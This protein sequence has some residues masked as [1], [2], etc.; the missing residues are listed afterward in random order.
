MTLFSPCTGPQ[1]PGSV[2]QHQSSDTESNGNGEWVTGWLGNSVIGWFWW[3]A[4]LDFDMASW[5]PQEPLGCSFCTTLLYRLLPER[6][7]K[8]FEIDRRRMIDYMPD[9]MVTSPPNFHTPIHRYICICFLARQIDCGRTQNRL[10]LLLAA[11]F[12]RPDGRDVS[13]AR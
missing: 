2:S 7:F 10:S 12:A 3:L 1:A 5:I 6:S 4:D 13:I 11:L 8:A 9:L